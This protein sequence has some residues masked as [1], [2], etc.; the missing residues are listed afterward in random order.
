MK[1]VLSYI[2]SF[3]MLGNGLC[4]ATSKINRRGGID[5]VELSYKYG[6]ELDF[7]RYSTVSGTTRAIID[8]STT[9]PSAY[10]VVHDKTGTH[11][12]S[13]FRT[14]E[15]QG[16][17]EIALYAGNCDCNDFLKKEFAMT[18]GSFEKPLK[19]KIVL[20]PSGKSRGHNLVNIESNGRY[21]SFLES[22]SIS[23][24]TVE[25]TGLGQVD[26]PLIKSLV[27]KAGLKRVHFKVKAV[28]PSDLEANIPN[29]EYYCGIPATCE[30]EKCN[31]DI[32]I[33]GGQIFDEE[34]Y[35]V[36]VKY[37]KDE[38]NLSLLSQTSA[39]DENYLSQVLKKVKK[40]TLKFGVGNTY[41]YINAVDFGNI[42]EVCFI[43]L[44]ADLLSNG[45][46][47]VLLTKLKNKGVRVSLRDENG[48]DIAEEHQSYCQK[49][50]KLLDRYRVCSQNT[51]RQKLNALIDC[52]S[53]T[54]I[55]NEI[56]AKNQREGTDL[57]DGIDDTAGLLAWCLNNIDIVCRHYATFFRAA[58]F[59]I[60]IETYYIGSESYEDNFG[61]MTSHAW[62]LV[63]A[64]TGEERKVS[65][66]DATWLDYDSYH[67]VFKFLNS[68]YNK[69]YKKYNGDITPPV[70]FDKSHIA[71]SL[72]PEFRS[73][74]EH[75]HEI[76]TENSS[77]NGVSA[78]ADG[79]W[80]NGN[81]IQDSMTDDF[82][83][84]WICLMATMICGSIILALQ[85]T[86]KKTKNGVI[87][88]SVSPRNSQNYLERLREVE[89]RTAV[90]RRTQ[91]G[92]RLKFLPKTYR[93]H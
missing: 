54:F 24:L 13:K 62:N 76:Y 31:V 40:L 3:A 75:V 91:E 7:D 38:L 48:K 65:Y 82:K 84:M 11:A 49:L 23:E 59:Y 6:G 93:K 53:E 15:L 89:Q 69:Y 70:A 51:H 44:P 86:L 33:N 55:Y 27:Q 72:P 35:G 29:I 32:E 78:N 50:E 9:T 26:T 43:G 68:R 87:E 71:K 90:Y 18:F 37:L 77:A 67:R 19:L 16:I 28:N 56:A 85:E 5:D 46:N 47:T 25:C 30:Y 57:D 8:L 79:A 61:R 10:I 52:T 63:V 81:A 64:D 36:Y 73:L 34:N 92:K 22:A 20:N 66:L 14:S 4:S 17:S 80:A 12:R 21:F 45:I 1:K 41:S 88:N 60:D 2:L 39:L 74:F 58:A 42:S 83:D